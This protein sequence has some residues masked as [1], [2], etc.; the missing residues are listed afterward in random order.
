MENG[1]TDIV[2]E[3]DIAPGINVALEHLEKTITVAPFLNNRWFEF[4]V[5]RQR[6]NE[7][8]VKKNNLKNVSYFD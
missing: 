1:Y 3:I 5:Q 8:T 2:S 4:F 6:K 7:Y